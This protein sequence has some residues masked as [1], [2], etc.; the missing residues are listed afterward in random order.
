MESI[1][2]F[3]IF[4]YFIGRCFLHFLP[5]S[6]SIHQYFTSRAYVWKKIWNYYLERNETCKV[7]I[8]LR[9]LFTF[10]IQ[11]D[12]KMLRCVSPR[13][14]PFSCYGEGLF[15]DFNSLEEIAKGFTFPTATKL[16]MTSLPS[17]RRCRHCS[18]TPGEKRKTF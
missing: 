1:I 8:T 2:I 14:I 7:C 4:F 5:S 18:S 11:F 13:A 9:I 16:V 17:L 6:I 10:N 15:L 12:V 3:C